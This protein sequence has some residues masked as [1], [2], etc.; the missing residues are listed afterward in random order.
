[1]VMMYVVSYY[2]YYRYYFCH[3]EEEKLYRDDEKECHRYVLGKVQIDV[4]AKG[5][6]HMRMLS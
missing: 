2:Y 4:H 6:M 5:W 3:E 1:M